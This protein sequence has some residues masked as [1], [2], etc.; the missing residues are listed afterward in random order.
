LTETT[1]PGLLALAARAHTAKP[2]GIAVN[3]RHDDHA[4]TG[5][6][7]SAEYRLAAFQAGSWTG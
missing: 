1:P 7:S 5:H 4:V 3:D 2:G 6:R